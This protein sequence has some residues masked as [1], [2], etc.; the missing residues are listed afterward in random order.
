MHLP[1]IGSSRAPAFPKRLEWLNT[2]PLTMASLAGK[3]VLVHFWTSSCVNCL[4]SL[5]TLSRWHK[6]YGRKDLVILGVHAP[7]FS[8]EREVSAVERVVD[9]HGIAYPIVLD[10]NYELWNA[11]ANRSRP[12]M[13]LISG[14]GKIVFDHDGEDGYGETER[15]IQAEL[16][17]LGKKNFS[18][19]PDDVEPDAAFRIT[20]EIYLGYL[21]GSL[22]NGQD[23]LPDAEHAFTDAGAHRD[24]VPYLHGHWEIT[25]EYATHARAL[26]TASEYI[27]ITYSGCS[28]HAVLGVED[29]AV[30]V[31]ITL[32][33]QPVPQSMRGA[34]LIERGG[35]TWVKVSE[36]RL[37]SLVRAN[38]YH[39]GMLKL[40]VAE[41]GL[42]CFA[43][44]FGSCQDA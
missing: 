41:A 16:M 35:R 9:E 3:A 40:K 21:R 18:A 28:A 8:F 17:R 26:P 38:I 7:E 19:V 27:A 42:R 13:F 37:Y 30:F 32:D 31:E 6:A 4:R 1:F 29:A 12:R 43:L 25:K 33:E 39:R 14:E 15:A 20:P 11:Y 23:V 34:D 10:N 24:D 44:S 5:A 2:K 36:S 22:G